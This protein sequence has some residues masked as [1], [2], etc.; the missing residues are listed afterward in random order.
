MKR[1]ITGTKIV[2][3]FDGGLPAVE[4]S[5]EKTLAEMRAHAEMHGWAAKIGDAAA[6]SRKQ[7]DGS[8]IKVTEQM[9]RDEV[10]R[11]VDR[12]EGGAHEWN[13]RGSPARVPAIAALAAAKGI[14]YEEC[15]AELAA[16]AARL[17]SS[18]AA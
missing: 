11:L 7:P 14:T 5:A 4:F 15:L 18:A 1:T 8:V 13:E 16:E 12:F 6:L 9:R 10:A 17:V 3:S 2:F